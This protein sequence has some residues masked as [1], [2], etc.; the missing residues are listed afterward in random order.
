MKN[1]KKNYQLT[2]IRKNLTPQQIEVEKNTVL[3]HHSAIPQNNIVD[4]RSIIAKREALKQKKQSLKILKKRKKK[5][6]QKLINPK[7]FILKIKSFFNFKKFPKIT[8]P[9][10][11]ASLL[12]GR[13]PCPVNFKNQTKSGFFSSALFRPLIS[14]VI[15]SLIFILPATV[16]ATFSQS[17]N[18]EN[19]LTASAEEALGHLQNALASMEDFDF[20]AATEEFQTAQQQFTLAQNQVNEINGL[21]RVIAPY[22]PGQGKVFASG[23]HL[24]NAGQELSLAGGQ[25]AKALQEISQAD[26]TQLAKDQDNKLTSLLV[27]A[28]AGLAPAMQNM[29]K[30]DQELQAVSLASIPEDKRPFVAQAQK[31]LPQINNAL[32]EGTNSIEFLL[33][34]LGHNNPQRHLVL[35]ANNREIRPGGG[36]IG[37]LGL[38]D[39]ADGQVSVVSIPGGG[40]YDIA[41]QVLTKS[42]APQPL[43]LINANWNIQDANWFPHYPACAQKI[44]KFLEDNNNGVSVDIVE[45]INPDVV[46]KLLEITGPLDM[47][48]DYGLVIS[49]DNFYEVV[50]AQAEKKFEEDPQSKRLIADMTPLLFDQLF[51]KAEDPQ[52]LLRLL[53]VLK[54]ALDKKDIVIYANDPHLQEMLSHRNWSGEIMNTDRDYLHINVANIGGGKTDKV[55]DNTAKITTTIADDGSV[56]DQVSFERVH[57]G[58]AGDPLTGLDNFS[59]VRFYLPL[60]SEILSTQGFEQPDPQLFHKPDP[61][62]AIDADLQNISGDISLNPQ[63][64]VYSNTEFNKQVVGGWIITEVGGSSSVTITY[65]LPFKIETGKLFKSSDHYSFFLQKQPGL[66]LLVDYDLILPSSWQVAFSYP[67]DFQAHSQFKLEKDYFSG[68]LLTR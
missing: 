30:A 43:Q 8:P 3:S 32:Q 61:S 22:F 42:V 26:I 40:I 1:T 46:E 53:T 65:Q 45:S 58:K 44:E 49:A 28:E 67:Q 4:L 54:E 64:N 31:S 16:R 33:G 57:K 13:K 60:G 17:S 35:F 38:F 7:L 19:S 23:V 9:K 6:Q 11:V 15:L 59:F 2:P 51:K 10:K 62:D 55:I 29:E 47:Q 48:K 5:N 24:L 68:I 50:Q 21:V 34:F 41:G 20:P 63:T 66:D 27:V 37:S 39:V 12:S 18:L 14:F 25:I 52:Q 56:I 36:F